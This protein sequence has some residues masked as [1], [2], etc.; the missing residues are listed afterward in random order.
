VPEEPALHQ[1]SVSTSRGPSQDD[2]VTLL[3]RVADALDALG[4]VGVVDITYQVDETDDGWVPSMTVFYEIEDDVTASAN[5]DSATTSTSTT[6]ST[7][8]QRDDVDLVAVEGEEVEVFVAAEAARQQP[9]PA[10]VAA[11]T[12]VTI[13]PPAIGRTSPAPAPSATAPAVGRPAWNAPAA[14]PTNAHPPT[15]TPARP[16]TASLSD[17][18]YGNEPRPALRKIKDLWTKGKRDR[19][20]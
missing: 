13:P 17:R 18:V 12:T 2:V 19:R 11:G 8:T 3:Y 16:P 9:A 15:A 14:R 1:F 10:A 20:Y 4:E 7:A 5:G 6:T